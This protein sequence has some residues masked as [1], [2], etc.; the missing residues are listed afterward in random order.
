MLKREIVTSNEKKF[1]ISYLPKKLSV[2]QMKFLDEQFNFT[3][4]NNTDIQLLWY[5]LAIGNH[6]TVADKRIEDYLIENG[7][8]WHIIPL[9]K[10]MMKT[11][12][13]LKRAKEIYKKAR[14]NYHPMTYMA[15]DKLLK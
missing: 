8:M 7:R 13:G 2:E 6:Y 9:Y 11:P 1:F 3:G 10:E 14:P 12:E 15:I 5:T 4:S